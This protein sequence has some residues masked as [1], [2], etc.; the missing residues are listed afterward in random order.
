MLPRCW[1]RGWR[2]VPDADPGSKSIG[3][4]AV[5][6]GVHVI[7]TARADS[8]QIT[9]TPVAGKDLEIQLDVWES[10]APFLTIAAHTRR[11]P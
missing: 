3:F 2:S 8:Q 6:D 11:D 9:I 5:W 10:I 4:P 7:A 1:P